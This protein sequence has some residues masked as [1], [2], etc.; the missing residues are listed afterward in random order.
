MK[1]VK[2]NY[3]T[4]AEF[5]EQNKANIQTFMADLKQVNSVGIQY[6]ICLSADG[7]TFTHLAFFKTDENQKSLTELP[8]FKTFQ[9]ELKA[10]K[11]EVP[12]QQEILTLVASS[13][14]LFS[15]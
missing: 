9:E 7:K 14:N 12:P 5:S 2:I 6:S 1:I 13:N 10:S 4:S 11:P 3:T 15:N 8:S